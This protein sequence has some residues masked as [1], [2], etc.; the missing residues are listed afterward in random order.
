MHQGICN[1]K[2]VTRILVHRACCSKFHIRSGIKHETI[3]EDA[4][5]VN[6]D[7]HYST[8]TLAVSMVPFPVSRLTFMQRGQKELSKGYDELRIRNC[9]VEHPKVLHVRKAVIA[10]SISLLTTNPKRA[11][12]SNRTLDADQVKGE[13]DMK[14]MTSRSHNFLAT[15]NHIRAGRSGHTI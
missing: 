3:G 12:C 11:R 15:V 4:P 8:E 13:R 5:M 9:E 2:E 14:L 7:P 10:Y 6:R 1:L